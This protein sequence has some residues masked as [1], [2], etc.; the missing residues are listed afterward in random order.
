MLSL[1][2]FIQIE[3]QKNFFYTKSVSK[4]EFTALMT[5]YLSILRRVD[6]TTS[7]YLLFLQ[8]LQHAA[9]N[10][11]DSGMK[12]LID[13]AFQRL[14]H[15]IE[16]GPNADLKKEF[17]VKFGREVVLSLPDP[18]H[19]QELISRILATGARDCNFIQKRFLIYSLTSL[20]RNSSL[21][22]ADKIQAFK[23]LWSELKKSNK[24]KVRVEL[25]ESL[26]VVLKNCSDFDF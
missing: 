3:Q 14:S 17:L 7:N 16:T 8:L 13:I 12:E 6:V 5:F 25:R 15:F 11:S 19:E 18:Q 23:S 10:Y 1:A 24:E 26:R 4:D 20:L 9:K 2:N 22:F 21:P